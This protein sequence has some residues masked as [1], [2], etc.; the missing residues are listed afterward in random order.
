MK[1]I[2]CL[3]LV[4]TMV[5]SLF[6]CGGGASSSPSASAPAASAAPSPSAEPSPSATPSAA[7]S[8]AAPSPSEAAPTGGVPGHWNGPDWVPDTTPPHGDA[9]WYTDKVDWF[10]RDPYKIVFIYAQAFALTDNMGKAFQAWSKRVNYEYTE[11]NANQDNDTFLNNMELFASQGWQGMVLQ[12]DATIGMRVKELATELGV[13]WM[14]GVSPIMDEQGNLLQPMV[15]LGTKYQADMAN[16]WLFDNYKT[17]WGNED[18]NPA[19]LG[20]ICLG[21]SANP[22]L[23]MVSDYSYE[24][25]KAKYPAAA[26]NA[27]D[28]D[29][30]NQTNPVSADAGYQLT[31]ATMAAH[32]EIEHWFITTVLEDYAQGAAR[33]ASALNIEN[34]V[35]ICS[36]GANIL[37]PMFKESSEDKSWVA[38]I[39]YAQEIFCEP[40]VCGIIAMLDGRATPES[41]YPEWKAPG[42]TYAN[43]LCDTRVVTKETYQEYLDYIDSY[44]GGNFT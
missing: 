42:A 26:N 11:S 16:D 22:I 29:C 14:P 12:P 41:L 2:L 37:I 44:I 30:I 32:P 6:A 40:C 1:K 21:L 27:F 17:Y 24:G 43:I 38:G 33:A 25:F 31:S 13:A 4:L 9:G 28:G 36:N 20:Y 18:I 35:L 8:E 5:F 3:V 19:T 39:Y 23:K 15:T 7:P 34:K 10:A